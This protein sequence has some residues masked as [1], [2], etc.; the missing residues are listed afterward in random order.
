MTERLGLPAEAYYLKATFP[1]ACSQPKAQTQF[2]GEIQLGV[3]ETEKNDRGMAQAWHVFLSEV[4][5]VMTGAGRSV[6]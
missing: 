4:L 3:A 2:S 1:S 5:N 6:A